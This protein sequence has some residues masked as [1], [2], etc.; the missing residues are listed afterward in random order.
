VRVRRPTAARETLGFSP[1]VKAGWADAS[2]VER[3]PRITALAEPLVLFAGRPAAERT[4]DAWAGGVEAFSL[5][6]FGFQ[7]Q[8]RFVILHGAHAPIL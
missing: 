8:G 7:N 2:S 4:S 3:V 6:K 5:I 1:L